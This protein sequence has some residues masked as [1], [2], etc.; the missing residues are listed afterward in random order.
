MLVIGVTGPTG[1]GKT[2]FLDAIRRRG[3]VVLDCDALYGEL[4]ETDPEMKSALAAAFPDA[5][6]GGTLNRRVLAAQVFSEPQALQRLNEIVFF[7]V[8][9]AVRAR[10]RACRDAPL[11]GIDAVNLFE[12]GLSALC[13]QTV[14]VLADIPTRLSRIMLR[15]GLTL[16]QARQ[17]VQAQKADDFYRARCTHILINS[18]SREAFVQVSEQ[19]IDQIM[20]GTRNMT[21]ELREK[22]LYSPE[23][24]YTR[25][26]KEDEAA[27]HTYCESYKDFL[28]RSKTERECV[29]SAV[30]LA[31]E[32]GFAEYRPGMVLRPG[33]KIYTT[34]RDK[35]IM[36]AV[37]GEKS[38]SEGANIAAA[39]TDSPRLD[40]KPN[41]V[42]QASGAELAY[43]KTHHYG[44]IRKYQWV[45]VPLE[46][47][48]KILRAD[49]SEVFVTLGQDPSDPQLVITDLLPHLAAEQGKKPLNDAIP[50]ESLNLLIGSWPEKD[51]DG[52]DRV[53][54]SVLRLLHEK[55]GVTEEDFVSAELEAVPALNARDV[56][57]DRSMIGAYGHD[58]RVCAFAELFA[59]LQLDTPQRTSVCI[60]AD[61]EEIGS[62]GVSGM[63]SEAFELFMQRLCQA[64]GV[65]LRECFAK[66]FCVSADVAAAYDPSFDSVFERRNSAFL[67]YGLAL[68]KYTGS[69]GKAG[70]S[71]ASA[72]AVGKLRRLLNENNVF[73]QICELGK[74]EAG[75]G[76]TVAMF[77]AN[78]N[79]DTI[80][81]GVPVLSMHAPYEIVSKLDCYMACKGMRA[82]FEGM[83]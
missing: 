55:Y 2:T 69:R 32:H 44:G 25:L 4:L 70:A 67:N 19:L 36:L 5:F 37:I 3:G 10:L 58:D 17:R 68:C 40:L 71:D 18:T 8:G 79:I 74:N 28:D 72:E 80:D 20:K 27:M 31:E 83:E 39:H 34:N 62:V 54:L 76:G 9:R 16:A 57:L 23:N 24:G 26:T 65:S 78:R 64:Q 6:S 12:S 50:S 77:M 82:F 61:K 66:S 48:G 63:Q 49:G 11:F 47:H 1:C 53:K 60:F 45:S 21:Q 7:Y 73:W 52:A 13:Q 33:S 38:L 41:P 35:G 15:D 30:R 14:G 43:L 56:G 81:A 29:V 46:L 75:G 59:L 42:F 22:L 51:D